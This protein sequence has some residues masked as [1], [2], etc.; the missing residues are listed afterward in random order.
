MEFSSGGGI[1]YRGF[2][3]DI[4]ENGIFISTSHSLG[5]GST[6][7]ITVYLPDGKA[8]RLRGVVKRALKTDSMLVRN[9]MGVEVVE[10]DAAYTNFINEYTGADFVIYVCT[11]CGAKN[12][13]PKAKL[14]LKP[15]CGN[16][17]SP[18]RIV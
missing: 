12:K 16:C 6:L 7:D 11:E 17:K 9:G 1:T 5:E 15:K 4:S 13:V 18:L 14:S 10:K 2:T 3:G 8:A